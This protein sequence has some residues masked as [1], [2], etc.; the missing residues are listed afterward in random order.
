MTIFYVKMI[1][2]CIQNKRNEKHKKMKAK[3][4]LFSYSRDI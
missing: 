2:E 3:C 4:D 1:F